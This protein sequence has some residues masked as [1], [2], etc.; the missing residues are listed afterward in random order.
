MNQKQISIDRM[1]FTASV[2]GNPEYL[3]AVKEIKP[4]KDERHEGLE[5]LKPKPAEA[6]R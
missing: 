5:A 2:M 4:A 3:K 6:K 1:R